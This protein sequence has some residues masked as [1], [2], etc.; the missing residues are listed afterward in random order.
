MSAPSF[1]QYNNNN[2]LTT[3]QSNRSNIIRAVHRNVVNALQQPNI[4]I[5]IEESDIDNHIQTLVNRYRTDPV[6]VNTPDK[7][8]NIAIHDLS[9]S[10]IN[11]YRYQLFLHSTSK[12]SSNQQF[13]D[14]RPTVNNMSLNN[15]RPPPLFRTS[16]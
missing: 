9:E 1:F 8:I 11:A 6:M 14:S 12:L 4:Q 3:L 5:S 2:L 16:I 10:H 7:L 15:H 13:G